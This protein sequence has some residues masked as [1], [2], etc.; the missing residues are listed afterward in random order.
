M[1][2]DY[3]G[4]VYNEFAKINSDQNITWLPILLLID[5]NNKDQDIIVSLIKE[6]NNQV[7]KNKLK[8]FKII[9]LIF[10]KDTSIKS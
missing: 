3:F 9:I 7:N 8:I 2:K 10:K 1:G 5:L 4:D 6:I